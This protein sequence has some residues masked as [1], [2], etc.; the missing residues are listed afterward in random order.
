M[1]EGDKCAEDEAGKEHRAC[2]G[3]W[4]WTGNFK[5]DRT[6]GLTEKMPLEQRCKR[7]RQHVVRYGGECPDGGKADAL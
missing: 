4:L 5:Y 1:S 2:L 3:Q 6:G 7:G